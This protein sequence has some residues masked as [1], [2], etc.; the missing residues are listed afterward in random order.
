MQDFSRLPLLKQRTPMAQL[1][2]CLSQ[3]L[4][5]LGIMNLLDQKSVL[6]A[7]GKPILV[8]GGTDGAS[9]NIAQ[10]NGMMGKIQN[11][12]PCLMWSWCYA[13]RLELS[14]KKCF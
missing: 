11:A 12:Q 3:S 13:H 2:E 10:Q 8:G 4:L 7:E 1:I 5:P 9:I 14:C 6:D